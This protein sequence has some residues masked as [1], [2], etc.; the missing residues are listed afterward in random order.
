MTEHTCVHE[1]DWG[2]FKANFKNIYELAKDTNEA[3]RGN[4]KIGLCTEVALI[5]QKQGWL[6]VSITGLAT[7]LLA[8]IGFIVQAVFM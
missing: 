2:E 1:E 3:I 6:W 4:G 5:K 8:V 7:V